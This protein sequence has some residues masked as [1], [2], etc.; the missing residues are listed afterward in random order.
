M[1]VERLTDYT[2]RIWTGLSADA[3]DPDMQAGDVIYYM[4]TSTCSIITGIPAPGSIDTEDLPDIG[5]GG[6]QWELIGTDTRE[7]EEYTNTSTAQ[8]ITTGIRINAS[9]DYA[10]ILVIITCDTPVTTDTEWGTS[11]AVCGRFKSSYNIVA[12]VDQVV[13]TKGSAE[14]SLS[15]IPSNTFH[16]AYGVTLA[17]NTSQI[18]IV[19]KANSSI[20][21]KIRGGTYTVKAYGLKNV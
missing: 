19:R 15:A 2:R 7:L 6:A 4:D 21:P 17:N 20:V 10:F 14:L 12:T 16:G 1:A 11:V 9:V 13:Q 3:P 18:A 5:G 8:T